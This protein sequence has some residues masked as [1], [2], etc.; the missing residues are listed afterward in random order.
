MRVTVIPIVVGA[1][2]SVPKGLVK[3]QEELEIRGRIKTI[4][5]TEFV[6]SVKILRKVQET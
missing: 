4:Q 6:R 1:L 2:G 3:K 5:T